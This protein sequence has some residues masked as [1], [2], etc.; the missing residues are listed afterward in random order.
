MSTTDTHHSTPVT[1]TDSGRGPI[2]PNRSIDVGGHAFVHR[3]RSL[4]AAVV[5]SIALMLVASAMGTMASRT[6]ADRPPT[7]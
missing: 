1:M 3:R 2:V 7:R 4:V 6:R 5:A